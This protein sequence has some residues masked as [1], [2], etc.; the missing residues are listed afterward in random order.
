M[1]RLIKERRKRANRY[2]EFNLR[3]ADN[4]V[5]ALY[6]LILQMLSQPVL[7]QPFCL[8][9]NTLQDTNNTKAW[10]LSGEVDV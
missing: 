7:I 6:I 9:L 1:I 5:G 10:R 3:A 4:I 8:F 2:K